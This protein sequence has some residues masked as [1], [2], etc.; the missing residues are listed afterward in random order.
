MT[1]EISPLEVFP[2]HRAVII[3]WKDSISYQDVGI[4]WRPIG[5]MRQQ[6]KSMATAEHI[7]IGIILEETDDYVLF[8]HSMRE[9]GAVAASMSL[10]MI[11]VVSIQPLYAESKEQPA[12]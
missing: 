11:Q 3:R 7:S 10:P 1:E 5:W 4:V 2:N 12:K 9:D 6:A 8:C